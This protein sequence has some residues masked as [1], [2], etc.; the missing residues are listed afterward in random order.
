MMN[1]RL[2]AVGGLRMVGAGVT[3]FV[4]VVLL[5]MLV[6][7]RAARPADDVPKVIRAKSIELVDEEGRVRAT[8]TT[9]DHDGGGTM[10]SLTDR[11]YDSQKKE[12]QNAVAEAMIM[13]SSKSGGGFF[14]NSHKFK[15]A[16]ALA[17]NQDGVVGL[18]LEGRKETWAKSVR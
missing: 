6:A 9:Y 16:A 12:Q 10:L 2:G 8:L 18:R 3:W 15:S 5:L 4:T 7:E 14:L 13:A 11:Q 1:N 17:I